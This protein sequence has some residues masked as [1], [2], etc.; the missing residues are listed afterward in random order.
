[1]ARTFWSV[2][3]TIISSPVR[4]RQ[5]IAL[6]MVLM[7][8]WSEVAMRSAM[9]DCDCEAGGAPPCCEPIEPMLIGA[10]AEPVYGCEG[11]TEDC[12]SGCDSVC[13][14]DESAMLCD[15]RAAT[16]AKMSSGVPPHIEAGFGA[17][18]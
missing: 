15:M 16:F 17:K 8:P 4:A 7:T 13:G 10:A 5:T 18:R 6:A 9:P 1:M 3:S 14:C 11:G 2:A 12:E